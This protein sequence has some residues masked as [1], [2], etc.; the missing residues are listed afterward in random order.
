MKV[1]DKVTLVIVDTVNYGNAV[2]SLQK[3]LAQIKPARTIFFTDI[4]LKIPIP[5][6]ELIKIP[7]I[8]SKREYSNFIVKE[9]AHYIK[10]DYVLVTQ[11]DAW[12]L[13]GCSWSDEYYE[14]DYIGAPW[15]YVDNRNVG[16]GGFSIRSLYL[17]NILATDDF[18]Q[19]CDPEDEVVSRLYGGYLEQKY[20]I[21]FPTEE[22]ADT[23]SFEL[24]T[25]ICKTFGF[26]GFFHKPYQ[27]TIMIT[28]KGAMGD[29]IALEPLLHY[30]F[31]K[32]YRVVLNTMP[33]F[34]NLFVQHYFKIHSPNELDQRLK[35]KEIVLDMAYEIKPKQLHL[36]SYYD[37]C[38]IS[39]GEIRNPV[40]TMNFDAKANRLF[41]K[42]VVIHNDIRPQESRNIHGINWK[43]VVSFLKDHGFDVIQI[44]VG[45]HDLIEGAIFMSTPS[46]PMLLWVIGG[47]D[48]FI[49]IDSA[50]SHIAI[51]MNVPA[52]IFYGSVNPVYLIPD[53]SNVIAIN[54]HENKICE[55]PYCWHESIGCEGTKCYI[56]NDKPP[57]TQF[58]DLQV[59]NAIRDTIIKINKNETRI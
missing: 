51:S 8:H 27:E 14:Y 36:Q 31:K 1:L 3:S 19:V 12:V 26:H 7:T 58:K 24:R 35:V 15:L 10:T 5:D 54:N 40:L 39:D 2:N 6:V 33:Q 46:E 20:G 43:N 41:K 18:I 45:E 49:G 42:Y 48:M 13:N 29:I 34:F 44:G 50:P 56:D 11:W 53:L 55:K 47:A 25:P 28:R 30:Y 9:L 21:K 59:L 23:F 17:Q 57:C 52:I 38:G 16:N 4:D 32:G 22:L 37:M